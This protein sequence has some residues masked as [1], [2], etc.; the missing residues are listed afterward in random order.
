VFVELT[1][2]S[3]PAGSNN[4]HKYY[5]NNYNNNYYNYYSIDKYTVDTAVTASW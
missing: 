4:E 1:Q 5:Y 3:L 2:Q